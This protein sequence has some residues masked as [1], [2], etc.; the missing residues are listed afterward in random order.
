M[1]N[2]FDLGLDQAPPGHSADVTDI[3]IP[4]LLDDLHSAEAVRHD[5]IVTDV[6]PWLEQEFK[7]WLLRP[8]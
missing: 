7:A 5:R 3:D 1:A 6:W 4:T 2:R 8:T